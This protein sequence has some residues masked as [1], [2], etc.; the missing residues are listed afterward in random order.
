MNRLKDTHHYSH[1]I[2]WPT[3]DRSSDVCKK[4]G[5]YTKI[6]LCYKKI[7]T[8]VLV[9][10]NFGDL[11]LKKNHR[12]FSPWNYQNLKTRNIDWL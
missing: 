8:Y 11:P 3:R 2:P 6:D 4:G 7:D 5:I 1:H 10:E 9:P 12:F